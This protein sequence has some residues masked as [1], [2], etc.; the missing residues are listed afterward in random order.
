MKPVRLFLLFA[1]LLLLAGSRLCAQQ[2]LVDSLQ[3]KIRTA[4]N[5]S[6]R[7]KWMVEV[8]NIYNNNLSPEAVPYAR[9]IVRVAEASG[10]PKLRA[11]ALMCVGAAYFFRDSV[12]EALTWFEK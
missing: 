2:P 8:L 1:S 7:V 9:Q 5:D 4:P 11:N 3:R 6:L 10:N 12:Q